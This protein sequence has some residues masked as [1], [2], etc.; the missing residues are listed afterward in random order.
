[1][2]AWEDRTSFDA[3]RDQ[4][5]LSARRRDQANAREMVGTL[6]KMWR[7]RHATDERP[8]RSQVQ[9]N[10]AGDQHVDSD[11]VATRILI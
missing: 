8:S 11:Q 10:D 4:F 6:F 3:I 9:R 5:G 1:M 7:K 2:M